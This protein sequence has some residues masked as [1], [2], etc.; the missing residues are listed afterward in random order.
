MSE[1][2]P[3]IHVD[4]LWESY[5]IKSRRGWRRHGQVRWALRDVSFQVQPG[6]LV[7]VVGKNGSGK[8]S[9]LQCLAGV[10]EPSRGTIE[11]T[12]PV[13]SLVDLAAG[14]NRE[15]TGRENV[16][17]ASVLTG[18]S[19]KESRKRY[20]RIRDFSELDAETL[21]API[22]T[23]SAGMIL[24]IGFAVAVESD[25]RI[26]LI[27]EVLAVG[28]ESFQSKCLGRVNELRKEGCAGLL[29]S[30]DLDLIRDTCGRALLLEEGV[31]AFDGPSS[32][33]VDRYHRASEGG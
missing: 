24:R 10:L 25:P 33:T 15:L 32:E 7:G 9:L 13:A 5:P 3:A 29:V 30:H 11:R 22:R 31:L 12:G 27:D 6:E 8:S 16:V 20:E 17:M 14:F 26:L 28:D 18:M 4:G 21:G 1:L 19:R 23:Y 2:S